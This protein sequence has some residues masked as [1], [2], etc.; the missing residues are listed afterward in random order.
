[1]R[2]LRP[3]LWILPRPRSPERRFHRR[4]ERL[5]DMRGFPKG[6]GRPPLCR[7]GGGIHKGGTPSKGSLPYAA[8]SAQDGY[9]LLFVRTKSNPG[10]GRGGPGSS[11]YGDGAPK[12]RHGPE[13]PK[14]ISTKLLTNNNFSGMLTAE[15]IVKQ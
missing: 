8:L 6:G 13:G 4:T 15:I 7:R 11:G 2:G 14:I 1:M 10:L 3:P 5:E 12:T 9:W